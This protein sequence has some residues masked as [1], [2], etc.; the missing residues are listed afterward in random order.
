MELLTQ[1]KAI[2][3]WLRLNFMV[4]PIFGLGFFM[5][6]CSASGDTKYCVFVGPKVLPYRSNGVALNF[7]N[8]CH[9]WKLTIIN[10]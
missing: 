8:F 10:M 4:D 3:N 5:N 9:T 2:R 7:S 6:E 1:K